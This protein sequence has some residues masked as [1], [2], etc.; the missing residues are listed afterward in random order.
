MQSGQTLIQ[1]GQIWNLM[2]PYNSDLADGKERPAVIVGWSEFGSN[3]HETIWFVPITA[4]SDGGR[5]LNS[6]ISIDNPS[7][8]N[9]TK[10]SWIQPRSIY[11]I[12]KKSFPRGVKPFG[13]LPIEIMISIY[14]EMAYVV[15]PNSQFVL[16][17]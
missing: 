17:K 16:I 5:V 8:F 3:E 14:E 12:D 10:A 11:S 7:A 13:T 6:E 1:I 15:N 4:H 2:Y 9:L